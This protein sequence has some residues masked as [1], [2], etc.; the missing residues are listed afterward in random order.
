MGRFAVD[1]GVGVKGQ[2]EGDA[3]VRDAGAASWFLGR[4]RARYH[5]AVAPVRAGF[6]NDAILR[7]M[8]AV[9]DATAG[10]LAA[11]VLAAVSD[12]H[13]DTGMWAIVFLPVWIV[14]AK[15][16]GLYDADQRSLRHLT[17]DEVPALAVWSI[18]GTV[19]VSLLVMVTPATEPSLAGAVS[20]AGTAFV[21][22]L[23]LRG[24]ARWSWR[25]LT[26]PQATL[27]VG[28]G[29][30]ADAV[31]RKLEL[32]PD[33]HTRIVDRWSTLTVGALMEAE[34]SPELDRLI[35]ATETLDERLISELVLFC[36]SHR[37][38]LSVIPPARGMFGTA[39][40]LD[41]VAELPIIQYNT[42]DVPRSTLLLKRILDVVASSIA[43]VLLAP[44]FPLVALAIKLDST[45]PI[46]FSQLRAGRAGRPYRMHKFRT[47]SCD[48][49]A[50]LPELVAIDSL[51]EPMFKFEDDPRRTR[52]GR[53][54]RRWSVDEL[55]QL[56]NV[57]RGEM[58][59]VGPRPEQL[60]VVQRYEPEHRVRLLVK[61]GITGPMQVFGRGRLTFEERLAVEREYIENLTLGRELRI[62]A[63]TV[64]AVLSGRGA[65]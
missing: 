16:Q 29:P 4:R 30:L 46:F 31:S 41:H 23:L 59:L 22:A 55:P 12:G 47:M 60:E 61:P 14:L 65:F 24:V 35:L 26:P 7:R 11:G 58:S 19:V 51:A 54:L 36:R 34:W 5:G 3:A 45:G 53:I 21:V 40:Q 8:L 52:V 48:A 28:D 62:L 50:R 32:F 13:L 6:W 15:L 49:E 1:E 18:L 63:L 27:I 44:V 42:W 10:L 56:W 9:A 43:L 38:K 64:S 17:V 25:R 2:L 57:L 39:V 20:A 37:I 33:T